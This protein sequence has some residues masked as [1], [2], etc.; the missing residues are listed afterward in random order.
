MNISAIVVEEIRKTVSETNAFAYL[1]IKDAIL[2]VLRSSEGP[3][4]ES[5]IFTSVYRLRR[6]SESSIYS[7]LRELSLSGYTHVPEKVRTLGI[8]GKSVTSPVY[9]LT[10]LGRDY[11]D[12]SELVREVTHGVGRSDPERGSDRKNGR[13]GGKKGSRT[14]SKI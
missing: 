7:G 10:K 8:T 11:I 6:C 13:R 4:T 2:F 12:M 3:L 9:G 14:K 5:K 1:K